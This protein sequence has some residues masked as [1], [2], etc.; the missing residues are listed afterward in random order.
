MKKIKLLG[1]IGLIG[2]L[3][4]FIDCPYY[5]KYFKLFFFFFWIEAVYEFFTKKRKTE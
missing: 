5:L 4:Y 1:F 2:F 3:P